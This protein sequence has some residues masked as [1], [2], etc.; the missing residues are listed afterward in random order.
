VNH[1]VEEHFCQA[2]ITY[3]MLDRGTFYASNP[4]KLLLW[5]ILICVPNIQSYTHNWDKRTLKEW[6]RMVFMAA[7]IELLAFL[8]SGEPVTAE[9]IAAVLNLFAF[10]MQQGHVYLGHRMLGLARN[11]ITAKGMVSDPVS[12][13]PPAA[14]L[15]SWRQTLEAAHGLDAMTRTVS[16]REL[17]EMRLPWIRHWAMERTVQNVIALSWMIK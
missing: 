5:S 14:G 9:V 3:P 13:N 6:T 17:D 4:S 1:F 12:L 16:S 10:L 11:L 8:A 2:D 15:P 7:K